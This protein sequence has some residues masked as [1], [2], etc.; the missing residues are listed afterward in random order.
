MEKNILKYLDLLYDQI[1]N[2]ISNYG[3]SCETRDYSCC[4]KWLSFGF[5]FDIIQTELGL[6]LAGVYIFVINYLK[7]MGD[8]AT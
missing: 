2:H 6:T 7:G 5:G 4:K 3:H 1:Y 8:Y